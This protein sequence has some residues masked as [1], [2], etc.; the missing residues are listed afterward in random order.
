MYVTR[1]VSQYIYQTSSLHKHSPPYRI[2]SK[3]N[4]VLFTFAFLK[5]YHQLPDSWVYKLIVYII[6][7][8]IAVS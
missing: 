2:N 1:Y 7:L 3:L 5:Q 8:M 6:G 4:T